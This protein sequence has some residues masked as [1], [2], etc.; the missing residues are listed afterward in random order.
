MMVI[1]PVS[2][3]DIYTNTTQVEEM[4]L[5]NQQVTPGYLSTEATPGKSLIP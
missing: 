1:A 4:K 3:T 5:E 2:T